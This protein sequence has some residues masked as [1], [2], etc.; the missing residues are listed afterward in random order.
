MLGG[1]KIFRCPE[2]GGAR[3]S[4]DD[5]SEDGFWDRW[6]WGSGIPMQGKMLLAISE[7]GKL[8]L[9]CADAGKTAVVP[10]EGKYVIQYGD[11]KLER[12]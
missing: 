8:L 9:I 3:V 12:Y 2:E 11:G 1:F 4:A 6:H 5:V 10:P 7:G